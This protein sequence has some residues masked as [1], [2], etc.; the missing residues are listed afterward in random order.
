LQSSGAVKRPSRSGRAS[1]RRKLLL[2]AL[3][4]LALAVAAGPYLVVRTGEWYRSIQEAAIFAE[5]L[6]GSL[7]RVSYESRLLKRAQTF[8][9]YLPPSYWKP[10]GRRRSY[11]VL[12]LLHGCPGQPRD[13][14]VK[15]D[16]HTSIERLIGTGKAREMIVVMVDGSGPRGRFDCTLYLDN[17]NGTYPA[18]AAF[19]RELIPLVER[20]F[21]TIKRPETRAV[22]GLSSGGYAALNLG[23]KHPELF[24]VL[25]AQSGYFR[26]E[27]DP[28]SVRRVLGSDPRLWADNSPANRL[29][30]AGTGPRLHIFLEVGTADPGRAATE[31]FAKRL[32]QLRIDHV[33]RVT[34]GSHTWRYWR[35][36]LPGSL[37]WVSNH[38][39][40]PEG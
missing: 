12:Y 9:V 27:D 26:A 36:S 21:R 30:E 31:A 28:R 38:L 39:C 37:V 11:P 20:R 5:H 35:S 33:L 32:Q 15:G 8:I 25:A 14:L 2:S 4:V 18:E 24:T 13:W 22:L 7:R 10:E 16:I 23:L 19:V 6:N 40:G 34:R 3:A 17:G 1:S 29:A